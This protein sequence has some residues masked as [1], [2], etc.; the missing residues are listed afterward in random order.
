MRPSPRTL[1]EVTPSFPEL[2]GGSRSQL[3][4]EVV[5]DGEIVAWRHDD[6]GG[7]AMPFSEIQKRLGCKQVS[8]ELIAGVPVA[9]VVFDVI[10]AEGELTLD[11]P[12]SERA[13]ILRGVLPAPS[14]LRRVRCRTHR[15]RLSFEPEVE[16]ENSFGMDH[17]RA[18]H[19]RR[20][21]AAVGA[22]TFSRPWRAAMKA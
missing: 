4:G 10:Y 16:E 5:L 6:D 17:S 20:L 8:Q 3:P 21:T 7:H 19:A 18:R 12:L 13:Q 15:P 11:R 2:V 22:N 14:G 1:D 9:Y